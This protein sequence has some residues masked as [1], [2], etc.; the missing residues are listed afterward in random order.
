M[1]WD[2]LFEDLEAQAEAEAAA[3]AWAEVAERSRGEQASVWLADRLR[4]H[5][6]VELGV[7]LRGGATVSGACRDVGPE[8]VVLEEPRGQALVPLGAVTSVSGLS[9]RVAPPA[10]EV[11]R[12][13]SLR[14]ALRGLARDRAPVRLDVDGA[15]LTGTLDRVAADHVDLAMHPVGER[16]TRAAVRE[17]RAVP[18]TALL[19]V[20][21]G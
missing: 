7:L 9:R 16:R 17:V 8:W 3:E 10:G 5:V 6:G 21:A 14:T 4:A 12:R 15:E 11:L 2:R 1:R 18:L 20:R 13:L 19:C